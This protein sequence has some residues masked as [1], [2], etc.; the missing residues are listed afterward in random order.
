MQPSSLT[1]STELDEMSLYYH[2]NEIGLIHLKMNGM[3][4]GWD[5]DLL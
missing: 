2:Y 1:N 5:C 4:S 3:R